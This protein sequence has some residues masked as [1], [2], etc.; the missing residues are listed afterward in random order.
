M[1]GKQSNVWQIKDIRD[2][3][4]RALALNIGIDINDEVQRD[5][6]STALSSL[7]SLCC[8]AE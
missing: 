3:V 5:V 6:R 4:H 1:A 8:L 7:S 2:T